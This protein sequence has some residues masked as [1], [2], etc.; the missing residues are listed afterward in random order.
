MLSTELLDRAMYSFWP[1][2]I[3]VAVNL[4]DQML[5]NVSSYNGAEARLV[6]HSVLCT[7]I[8]SPCF[9]GWRAIKQNRERQ[10]VS[11]G[12]Y[13]VDLSSPGE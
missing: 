3:V 9:C 12:H 10:Q 8:Y 2:I 4:D 6:C 5:I 13:V 11:D 1:R 7:N